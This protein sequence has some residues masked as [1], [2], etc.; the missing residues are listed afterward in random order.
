M[1][2]VLLTWLPIQA[3]TVGYNTVHA[4]QRGAL[5]VTA[6]NWEE[7][8]ISIEHQHSCV[9]GEASLIFSFL[10]EEQIRSRQETRICP[11]FL[12]FT[13][14]VALGQLLVVTWVRSQ[15][16]LIETFW[17]MSSIVRRCTREHPLHTKNPKTSCHETEERKANKSRQNYVVF[18]WECW[19][20]I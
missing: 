5:H 7:S 14:R 10:H 16:W 3:I 9:E 12:L 19:V 11:T 1:H 13:T 6:I 17:L 8:D 15:C 2:I 20:N 4:V 18:M